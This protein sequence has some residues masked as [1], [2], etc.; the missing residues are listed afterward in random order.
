MTR[1]SLLRAIASALVVVGLAAC[2]SGH[3]DSSSEFPRSQSLY[4][5]GG[6]WGEPASFNPLVS[7]PDTPV[8][9][10]LMYET[11]FVFNPEK[12]KLDGV[13]A[14][15]YVI[16]ATSI[17]VTLRPEPRWNDG[18]AVTAL[19]VKYS[20]DLGKKYKGVPVA[21]TWQYITSVS[22]LDRKSVG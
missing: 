13:L 12:G 15:S 3:D 1:F 11:L 9:G 5:G 8:N 18:K 17:D 16:T 6:Q 10:N 21:P 7:S 20:F 19:D 2:R 14:E 4:I 22:V